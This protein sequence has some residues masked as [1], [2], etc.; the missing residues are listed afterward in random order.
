[1]KGKVIPPPPQEESVTEKKVSFDEETKGEA[2]GE[3]AV[4]G[5]SL[6]EAGGRNISIGK[7]HKKGGGHNARTVRADQIYSEPVEDFDLAYKEDLIKM[8]ELGLPLGFLNVSPFEVE[9]ND[10]HVQVSSNP[11]V[12]SN[13]RRRK[14]KRVVDE[15]KQAEFDGGWWAE[16]GQEAIMKVWTE[17]YGQFMEGGEE[18]E[19]QSAEN[20][21]VQEEITGTSGWGESGKGPGTGGWGDTGQAQG[22]AWAAG[23]KAEDKNDAWNDHS[24]EPLDFTWMT[25]A[26][27]KDSEEQSKV[28]TDETGWNGI[29]KDTRGS[30]WGTVEEKT[31]E[32]EG[33]STWGRSEVTHTNGDTGWGEVETGGHQLDWDKLWVEVTNEVYKLELDKWI[34]REEE[35]GEEGRVDAGVENVT[36][37]MNNVSIAAD[38]VNDESDIKSEPVENSF[39]ESTLGQKDKN[40]TDT[41]KVTREVKNKGNNNWK[42]HQ[43]SSGIGHLLSKLQGTNEGESNDAENDADV[44][45]ESVDNPEAEEGPD[46]APGLVRALRAF[47]LLGYV[48]EVDAGDRFPDTPPIRTAAI[49]WRSKNAVKKSRYFNLS[50]KS[51]RSR[52]GLKMDETGNLLKPSALEKVKKHI[53][54]EPQDSASSEEFGSPAED[55]EKEKNCDSEEEF[56]TPEEEDFKDIAEEKFYDVKSSPKSKSR[57]KYP[58]L[59]R[60][61]PVPVPEELSSFPH[62]S[63]YWA[64]RYRLFSKYDDGVKLD[65]ESWYSI[66]PEKIAEHIA[67]RCRYN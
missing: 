56:F 34:T 35:E 41:N 46:E 38:K 20:S 29:S 4:L 6:E 13:R 65:Q 61:P 27:K 53:L 12:K 5:Q 58:K 42:Q 44:S 31:G 39:D 67:E 60:E 66:T 54:T 21:P 62:I 2:E 22:A 1:M 30:V 17:R 47:D 9:E 15:Y 49:E 43:L 51:D 64:Q 50:R 63:K 48:F 32:K 19:E 59:D 26:L 36:E 14:K 7:P 40:D 16:H 57:S 33:D 37:T 10:G 55:S 8:K 52:T 18:L 24:K 3:D 28:K 11:N 25:P 23:H 45:K